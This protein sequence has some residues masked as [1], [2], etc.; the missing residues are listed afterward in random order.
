[1]AMTPTTRL[2]LCPFGVLARGT[3]GRGPLFY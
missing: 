3:Y 2:G 1:M